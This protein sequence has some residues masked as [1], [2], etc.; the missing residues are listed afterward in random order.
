MYTK[1]NRY[2][3]FK[4]FCHKIKIDID[5]QSFIEKLVHM[6]QRTKLHDAMGRGLLCTYPKRYL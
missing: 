2:T 4:Q 1:N 6:I 5:F 3:Q